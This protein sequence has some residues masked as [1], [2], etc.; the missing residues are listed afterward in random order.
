MKITTIDLD[1]IKSVV[2][3][4]CEGKGTWIVFTRLKATTK[5]FGG[6]FHQLS[7]FY[8]NIDHFADYIYYH[9]P[10]LQ[11]KLDIYKK[12][13]Y[14]WSDDN[15][16]IITQG[17]VI[18]G[19]IS[20]KGGTFKFLYEHRWS[21][22]YKNVSFI[23]YSTNEV[24][25]KSNQISFIKSNNKFQMSLSRI[26]IN[27]KNAT[28]KHVIRDKN[29]SFQD[30]LF[31]S[32]IENTNLIIGVEQIKDDSVRIFF[33]KDHLSQGKNAIHQLFTKTE[34]M[35]GHIIVRQMLDEEKLRKAKS[36]NDVEIAYAARLK[37][38]SNPQGPD[39]NDENSKP[40]ERNARCFFGSSNV[41]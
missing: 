31:S 9:Q 26:I 5:N 27:V 23:P 41:D 35:F 13:I 21:G 17:V 6:W 39:D 38:I 30:W 22:R 28:T 29:I 34:E 16:K 24:F 15:K 8:H 40:A 19:D 11:G 18:D 7:S 33:H 10:H 3:T 14:A 25:T 12:Q 32:T 37:T 2:Y 1:T 20:V 4:W 36:S